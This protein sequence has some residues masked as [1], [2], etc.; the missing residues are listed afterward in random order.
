MAGRRHTVLRPEAPFAGAYITGD[1]RTWLWRSRFAHVKR[2][3]GWVLNN[4]STADGEH[5]DPTVAKAWAF[6]TAWGYDSM[7]FVN[8][9]PYR[10]TDPKLAKMPPEEVLVQND[11]WLRTIMTSTLMVVCGWG[12]KA[13]PELARRA[14]IVMHELGPLHALKVT[15]SGNPGHP[16]YLPGDLKPTLWNPDKCLH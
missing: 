15:K 14:V 6:S 2:A 5:N 4:P 16:L 9:N 1:Y 13:N 12:D 10:S 11:E 8:T 3:I 7:V